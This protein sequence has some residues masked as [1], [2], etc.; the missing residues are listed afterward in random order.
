MLSHHPLA[1]SHLFSSNCQPHLCQSLLEVYDSGVQQ[2]ISRCHAGRCSRQRVG[3]HGAQQLFS[4]SGVRDGLTKSMTPQTRG[5]SY[6][7][8]WCDPPATAMNPGNMP[9]PA[10]LLNAVNNKVGIF[11]PIYFV[12]VKMKFI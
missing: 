8:L 12:V 1:T 10:L 3:C 11:F 9:A 4:E 5:F 7:G 6:P 2:Q